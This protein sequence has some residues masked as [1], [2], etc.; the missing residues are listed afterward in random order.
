MSVA[1]GLLSFQVELIE[2][3]EPVTAHAMTPLVV[4][5]LRAV[6]PT[7]RYRQLRDALGYT[8]W[9]V[10]RRHLESL[11]VLVVSG[12]EHLSDLE[13]LRADRGLEVMLETPLSSPT[14]AKDFL[15]R[16]HQ[17]S[18]GRPLTDDDDARL[19]VPG[20]AQIRPDGPGLRVLAALLDDVVGAVQTDRPR[21][22][23]TLD[24]DATLV[25]SH[26]VEALPTYEGF[27]GYQPKMAWWAEQRVWV[28][29]QFRDGNV[30]DAFGGRA[31]LQMVFGALPDDITTRRLRADSALYD[32]EALTWADE[33]DIDFAV[34]ADMSQ[35]LAD[36]IQALPDTA[37]A[38][39]TSHDP[40][41]SADEEREWAEVVDF[42]PGWPRN[43][44]Q[45]TTPFRYIAIRIRSR[46]GTLFDDDDARWRHYAVVTNKTWRGDRV[47]RWHREKQGTV[48]HGHDVVKNDLGG[49]VLPCARFGANAGWWRINLIAD[50]VLTLLKVTALPDELSRARPKTLRLRV[51]RLP[52]RLI[53]HA[54][55]WILK[56]YRGFP[57][58]EAY[59]DARK[60]L[61]ALCQRLRAPPARAA[62]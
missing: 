43:Y 39:Y 16:L 13:V 23:A 2:R 41:A 44:K 56:L 15:Y 34:S 28:R 30:P 7:T 27:R 52:G 37:W 55:R 31:F 54:R 47:L 46:Q 26:K 5:A 17:A 49:G 51:F 62:G 42:I 38:P 11:V 61:A 60:A 8:N 33:Q 32:I 36:H 45:G 4:E 18:D 58:A 50:N 59:L 14:Q 48:E 10:V 57:Y 19:S 24:I 21:T 35:A 40:R 22:T 20:M 29:D 6:V 53:R 25:E 1:Q 3:A 12:G 9:K